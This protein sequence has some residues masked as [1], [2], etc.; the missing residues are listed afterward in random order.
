MKQSDRLKLRVEALRGRL[1]EIHLELAGLR[2]EAARLQRQ[3]HEGVV[4]A[5]V[6]GSPRPAEANQLEA[7]LARRKAAIS[8]AENDAASMKAHL[9]TSRREH[10]RQLKRENP[11]IYIN[12]DA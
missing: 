11:G 7:E 3:L 9:L 2:D 1:E 6:T 10:L 12:L 4:G 8:V 5:L